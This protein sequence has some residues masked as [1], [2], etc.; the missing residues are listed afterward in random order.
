MIL[1]RLWRPSDL[2]AAAKSDGLLSVDLVTLLLSSAALAGLIAHFGDI[3][4]APAVRIPVLGEIISAVSLA[5][6]T[7][8]SAA[9]VHLVFDRRVEG[10]WAAAS[11]MVAASALLAPPVMLMAYISL[12]SLRDNYLLITAL[13]VVTGVLAY[14]LTCYRLFYGSWKSAVARFAGMLIA[15]GLFSSTLQPLM[16]EWLT[17]PVAE[18]G[19]SPDA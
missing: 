5:A 19:N 14:I 15:S 6:P 3:P 12:E 13:L 11:F 10:A 9:L 17:P 16:P 4:L 18:S 1:L 7:I 2:V 8:V